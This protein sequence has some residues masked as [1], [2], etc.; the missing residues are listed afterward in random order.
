MCN[1]PRCTHRG[2]GRSSLLLRP[3]A[4]DDAEASAPAPIKKRRRV[5]SRSA[6]SIRSMALRCA[7]PWAASQSFSWSRS[8]VA[9]A[10]RAIAL[11][12]TASVVV[13]IFL[14]R[15]SLRCMSFSLFGYLSINIRHSEPL[16]DCIM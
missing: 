14:V 13:P 5:I 8:S 6:S 12:S 1:R 4:G 10:R 7:A 11:R 2:R 9:G 15:V 16:R 3:T